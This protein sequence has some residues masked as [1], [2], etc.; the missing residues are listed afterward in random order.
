MSKVHPAIIIM[1][2][3]SVILLSIEFRVWTTY[4]YKE[5]LYTTEIRAVE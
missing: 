1:I 3:L 5:A 2:I 4:S